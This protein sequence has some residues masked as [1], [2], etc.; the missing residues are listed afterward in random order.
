MFN[1]TGIYWVKDEARYIPEYIEFHLLQGFDHFIFYDNGSTDNLL[2]IIKPYL[3]LNIVEIRKYPPGL[4]RAKNMWLSEQ[5]CATEKGRSK[6]IHFHSIDERIFC[7]DGKLITQFLKDYEQYGGV[8]VA[9]EEFNSNYHMYRPEG[10]IIEN[11]TETCKDTMC[12]IKTIVQ[13]EF[14]L[15]FMGHP[16]N[17]VYTS[18]K[19]AVTENFTRVDT[20]HAPFDYS[21]K[22]IKNHH[23]RTLS[24][25]EFNIKMNKGVLD[26]GPS[27]E[28]IRREQ[29]EDEWNWCHGFPSR[30]GQT[31]LGYNDDLLKFVAPVKLAIKARYEGLESLLKEINH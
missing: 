7:P 11:Y 14:A 16:H 27:Q 24:S 23:Y 21:F 30:W 29:A 31:T 20:A 26:H 19:Y 4:D 9:W 22:K 18:G 8:S 2:E 3:D 5:C 13:P 10:L 12:A 1:L 25:E 17:C 15:G 6:W 28:L